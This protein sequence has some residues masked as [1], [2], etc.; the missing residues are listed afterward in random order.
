MNSFRTNFKTF[1]S[2]ISYLIKNFISF[3]FA[4]FISKIVPFIC[5]PLITRLLPNTEAF[6]V[7]NIFTTITGVGV[8]IVLLNLHSA[9]FREYFEYNSKNEQ[10]NVTRTALSIVLINAILGAA[11]I[12]LCSQYIS[13]LFFNDLKYQTV[14]ILS[15][16]SILLVSINYIIE[17]P[18]RLE[19]KRTTFIASKLFSSIGYYGIFL[20]LIV[21]GYTYYSI[22][23]ASIFTAILLFI[24]FS[25]LNKNFI[26]KGRYDKQIKRNLLNIGL[27]LLPSSIMYWA[28][29]FISIIMITHFLNLAELGIYSLTLKIARIGYVI[30]CVLYS[31]LTHFVYS[32]SKDN[33]YKEII[34][35]TFDW[36]LVLISIIYISIYFCRN[37]IFKIFAT[38]DYLDGLPLFKYLILVPFL[39]FLKN[40]LL[41]QF[42]VIKQPLQQ[43]WFLLLDCILLIT[44]SYLL[45]PVYGIL[46]VAIANVTTC[47]ITLILI[48]FYVHYKKSIVIIR[49]RTY[50]YIVFLISFLIVSYKYL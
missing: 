4:E 12:V 47:F 42:I 33:D 32:R 25:V 43:S 6:A 49:K 9:V 11:I 36:L 5:L 29:S 39:T 27:P 1:M 37:L 50:I 46:G 38:D 7:Y 28:Y 40:F 24:F 48:I 35:K 17:L 30:C 26:L 41:M 8:T 16:V 44:I 3:G 21:L 13:L 45:L 22:I 15:A 18:T 20:L 10:Y 2:R 34:G 14:V 31:S 23:F 19:N